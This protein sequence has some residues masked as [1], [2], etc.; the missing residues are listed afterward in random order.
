[1]TPNCHTGAGSHVPDPT[2]HSL[3][4]ITVIADAGSLFLNIITILAICK[5]YHWHA[6]VVFTGFNFF[7][8]LLALLSLS[9]DW[10]LA[11][12][13]STSFSRFLCGIRSSVYG[14]DIGGAMLCSEQVLMHSQRRVSWLS[15]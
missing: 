15:S 7:P 8:V 5:T 6:A 13:G 3:R 11:D 10:I 2:H 4:K 1:M 9:L 12:G 14:T